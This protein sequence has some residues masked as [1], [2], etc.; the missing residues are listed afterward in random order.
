MSQKSLAPQVLHPLGSRPEVVQGS[1][2]VIIYISD[3]AWSHPGMQWR[4]QKV[5]MEGFHSVACCG[6]LY[7]VCT[8]C[9]VTI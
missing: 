8:V 6:H 9:D 3:L 5:F 1:G 7:L 2:D 4:T